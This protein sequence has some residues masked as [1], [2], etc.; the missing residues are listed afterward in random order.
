MAVFVG[1][2]EAEQCRSHHQKMEKKHRNFRNILISLR[3]EHYGST[4]QEL[5]LRD[6]RDNGVALIDSILESRFLESC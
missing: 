1:S 5:V 6:L 3:N 4:R 2:R